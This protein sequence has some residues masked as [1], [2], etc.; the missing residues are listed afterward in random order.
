M[1]SCTLTVTLAR[2]EHMVPVVLMPFISDATKV[3]LYVPGL[4]RRLSLTDMRPTL[5]LSSAD[6][7][8]RTSTVRHRHQQ[9][10]KNRSQYNQRLWIVGPKQDE[11]E[12]N[13]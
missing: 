6:L 13:Q 2:L 4:L 12:E 11:D 9:S 3:K 7:K 10:L 1:A 5:V 8:V